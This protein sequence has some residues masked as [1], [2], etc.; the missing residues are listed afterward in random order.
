M[1]SQFSVPDGA[2][3]SADVKNRASLAGRLRRARLAPGRLAQAVRVYFETPHA[4]FLRSARLLALIGASLLC[5]AL[6]LRGDGH[7]V[8]EMAAIGVASLISS[9]AGFAFSAICG[10]ML[11][12]LPG[13]PVKIVQIMIACSIANQLAMAWAARRE[14]DWR[15]LSVFLAGGAGGLPVGI[16][17]LLHADRLIY[18]RVLGAFLLAY[19]VYMLLRPPIVLRRQHAAFDFVAGILGGVSGGAVGFP[20]AF[21]TIWCGMKGWDKARQRAIFQPFI[22]TMQ[23]IALAAISLAQR[24]SG[25]SVGFD[26]AAL[27]FIPGALLGTSLGLALYRR[28]S[29]FEFSRAVNVLLIVSGVS[30]IV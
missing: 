28:L 27:L 3:L 24:P 19:G 11:F 30:F 13:E 29:D 25:H 22:L 15:G 8:I 5:L 18:T 26:P 2:L 12:H 21:V 1:S 6:T 14:I 17:V 16:W 7:A 9:I 20:G 10:A 4:T 23:V